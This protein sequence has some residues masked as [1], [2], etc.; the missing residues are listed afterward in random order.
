MGDKI[1]IVC[2]EDDAEAILAFLGDRIEMDWDEDHSPIVSKRIVVTRPE[3][4]GKTFG[5]MHF[6]SVHGVNI[7]RFTRSGMD[8]YA[9]RHLKLQ[10]GDRLMVVGTEANVARVANLVGNEVKRLNHPNIAPIFIGILLGI[11]LGSI[12]FTI[13]GIPTPG[14]TI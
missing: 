8:L 2:A 6:N 1:R 7:T 9:D 11:L 12:P 14:L 13:S 4:E 10:I 3:I 5:Q